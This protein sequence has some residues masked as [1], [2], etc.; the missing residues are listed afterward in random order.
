[1]IRRNARFSDKWRRDKKCVRRS[2]GDRM[3]DVGGKA[4]RVLSSTKLRHRRVRRRVIIPPSWNEMAIACK[5][6]SS[7]RERERE[8]KREKEREREREREKR[9][10]MYKLEISYNYRSKTIIDSNSLRRRELFRRTRNDL[11]IFED[12]RLTRLISQGGIIANFHMTSL[13]KDPN[14]SE[15][16]TGI[17]EGTE[18]CDKL[19]TA[20]GA[21]I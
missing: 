20:K 7:S 21:M 5:L 9:E 4:L 13:R 2:E 11:E 15:A 14:G 10:R 17:R 6:L 16:I 19:K 18:G 1:M 12:D 3:I 8:R